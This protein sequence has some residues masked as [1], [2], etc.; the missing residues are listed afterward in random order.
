VKH[1]ERKSRILTG[2]KATL[3]LAGLGGAYLIYDQFDD[4]AMDANQLLA[5]TA[6]SAD[7]ITFMNGMEEGRGA[8]DPGAFRNNYYA[9]GR[10]MNLAVPSDAASRA[11]FAAGASDYYAILPLAEDYFQKEHPSREEARRAL[12]AI[13][14]RAARLNIYCLAAAARN[15]EARNLLLAQT[16]LAYF[17]LL[18]LLLLIEGAGY[19]LLNEPFFESLDVLRRKVRRSSEPFLGGLEFDGSVNGMHKAL[20]GLEGVLQASMLER[21]RMAREATGRQRHMKIQTHA[22]EMTG[23]KVVSLV[24]DL[25]AARLE[26]QREKK[27]LKITGEKLARSNKELEQFAYVASHD[28]KEPLRIVSSFTGL[29]AK[30]YSGRFDRDADDFIRYITE[31]AQRASDLVNALFN[32]SRVTYSPREFRATDC[33][34][35]LQKALFNLKIAIDEK[36]A[37]ITWEK[38][39]QIRGDEP[40][41]IQLFQN[42]LSNAL[43]FNAAAEPS[44]RVGCRETAASWILDFQDNGIGIP[45]EHFERIFLIFQRLHSQEKYP[46]AGIGLAL[47]KKIA[48]NHGGRI[49]VESKPGEGSVFSVELPKMAGQET[50]IKAQAEHSEANV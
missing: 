39:P 4:L 49:W 15:L 29:L 32:Y 17:L 24:E 31:G 48:E 47:C 37:K 22:L 13:K 41:L 35:A 2:L 14:A 33:Q 3:L 16:A 5:S 46:G 26:L 28:L 1:F 18:I 40:Q 36:K 8:R 43:K 7:F 30:R 9:L 50:A 19:Y 42:L 6:K 45:A 12:S 11:A 27:A 25:E 44:F 23:R 38:L 34:Q 20:D 21:I 10:G